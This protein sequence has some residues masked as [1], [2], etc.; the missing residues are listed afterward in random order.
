MERS[1]VNSSLEGRNPSLTGRIYGSTSG[2]LG[3]T[4]KLLTMAGGALLSFWGLQKFNFI[5]LLGAAAGGALLYRGATGNWPGKAGSEMSLGTRHK[6]D[7]NTWLVIDKPRAELY[8]YWRNLENL[9]N[10]MSHLERV[11]ET[12]DTRSKWTAKIPGG[13]GTIAWEAE[14][15]R[16]EAD[17]H[18]SWQSLP[19][20]E[21]HN[22][23]EVRFEDAPGGKTTVETTIS[24]R[25]PA[26]DIGDIVAQLL[27]PAFE[28]IVKKDLMEFK[29]YMEDGGYPKRKSEPKS[30]M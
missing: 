29:K 7:I 22:S 14:I 28:K 27:N 2:D 1:N 13:I 20:A 5:G 30:R 19:D 6:I 10:F 24:Y 8:A 3:S 17:R 23:G 15:I 21:I 4:E 12:S 18:I 9:P 11:N 16:E 26:G 25:P